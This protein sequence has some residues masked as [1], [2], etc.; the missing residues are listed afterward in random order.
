MLHFYASEMHW[1]ASF[2]PLPG[3]CYMLG[4]TVIGHVFMGWICTVPDPAPQ[5]QKGRLG[6]KRPTVHHIQ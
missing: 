6:S 2:P 5:Y 3:L 4:V 1:E